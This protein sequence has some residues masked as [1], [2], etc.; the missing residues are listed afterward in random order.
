MVH[1]RQLLYASN[2][3]D[4][5]FCKELLFS[6]YSIALITNDFLNLLFDNTS[7]IA[8][9]NEDGFSSTNNP[10]F[11]WEISFKL[12]KL[13]WKMLI[14]FIILSRKSCVKL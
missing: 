8:D 7:K 6:M 11:L 5:E 2:S 4:N 10:F 1:F 3:F 9:L 13:L 12:S 14:R